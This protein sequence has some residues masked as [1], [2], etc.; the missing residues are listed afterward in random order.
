MAPLDARNAREQRV[1]TVGAVVLALALVFAFAILPFVRHWRAREVT[2]NAATSRVTYLLSLAERADDL[3]LAAANAERTL[4]SQTRRV[5]HARSSTLAASSLQTFLQD[6]ADASRLAVT[7]LE[8]SPDDSVRAGGAV[9]DE[10]TTN[11]MLKAG[12]TRLPALLSAYGDISGVATLLD[13]LASGPRVLSVERLQLVRNSALLGAPDV[14]QITLT[15][16]A[17]VLPQ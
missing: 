15:L 12:V 2:L 13:F 7:R 1:I 8:V 10:S 14:V 17:P 3:E 16:R 11:G 9:P 4:A 5:L 6:A